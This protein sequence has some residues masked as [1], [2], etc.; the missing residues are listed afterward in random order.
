MMHYGH[1]DWFRFPKRFLQPFEFVTDFFS[2]YLLH[3][4]SI[5]RFI[6]SNRYHRIIIIIMVKVTQKQKYLNVGIN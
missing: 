3:K 4:T 2:R 5:V 1:H 6:F